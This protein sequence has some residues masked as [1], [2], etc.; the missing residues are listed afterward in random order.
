MMKQNSKVPFPNNDKTSADPN[1]RYMRESVLVEKSGQFYNLKNINNVANDIDIK[2]E[3]L[4]KYIQKKLGQPVTL[5][6]SSNNY[7]IK[8]SPNDVEKYVEQFIVENL[9]CKKCGIPEVKD[10]VCSSCGKK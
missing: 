6:K 9:V 10:S 3:V 7:K 4:I 2:V 5:D 1:Y 8:S